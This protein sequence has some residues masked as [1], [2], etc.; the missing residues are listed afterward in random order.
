M[1]PKRI[2]TWLAIAFVIWWMIKEPASAKRFFYDY[3][4][5]LTTAANGISS[6][7]TRL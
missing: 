2:L 1:K 5:L 3:G 6:F 7:F 4:R